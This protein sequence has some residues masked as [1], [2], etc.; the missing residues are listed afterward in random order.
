[1][2][3]LPA[4]DLFGVFG[5]SEAHLFIDVLEGIEGFRLFVLDYAN[6]F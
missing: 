1:M 2:V 5:Q 3:S 6:L 4:M